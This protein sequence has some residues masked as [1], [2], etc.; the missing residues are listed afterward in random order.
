ME[1]DVINRRQNDILLDIAKGMGKTVEEYAR[2]QNVSE[3]TI[4]N[5][6]KGLN[7]L[8]KTKQQPDIH[9]DSGGRLYMDSAADLSIINNSN[10]YTYKLSP[11]ERKTILSMILLNLDGYITIA[12]LSEMVMMSRNTILSDMDDLKI[13]FEENG[14]ALYSQT[15]KGFT[16]EGTEAN[17]RAGM[18]KLLLLN[19]FLYESENMLASDIFHSL[20]LRVLNKNGELSV[21][22]SLLKAT[23]EK[24]NVFLT[25]FSYREM[26]YYLLVSVNRQRQGKG[27]EE[28]DV[29]PWQEVCKSSKCG[30]AENI[31]QQLCDRYDMPFLQ[32]ELIALIEQLRSKSYIKNNARSIDMIDIQILI[33]EFIYKISC[34]YDIHYYLD[35]Y[36]HDLL[37]NHLKTAVY[38][39]RQNHSLQNTLLHQLETEYPDMFDE[40]EKQLRP[41]EEYIK[42]KISRH[43]ISFIVI[44]ILAVLEKNKARDTLINTLLVCNSGRGTAQL[45]SAKLGTLSKQIKIINIVSSHRIQEMPLKDIDLVVTTVP[46]PQLELPCV[47]INPI[48]SEA[49]L[50]SIQRTVSRMLSEKRSRPDNG[51]KSQI[52]TMAPADQTLL[53]QG[54]AFRELLSADMILLDE[55]AEDWE[56][57][58][59]KA[60]HIL[61]EK[62]KVEKRYIR[63][64]IENIHL[65][66][67]YVV[68]YPGIAIPH[69][70]LS[71]GALEAG[72]SIVRLANPVNFDHEE[73]DP[74]TFVIA[75]S[76]IDSV[77]IGRALYNLSKMLGMENF[78]PRLKSA[79]TGKELLEVI[80]EYEQKIDIVGG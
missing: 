4:K 24:N 21:I 18:L 10:F 74:V 68:I 54:A 30:M 27:L 32:T 22:Q 78:I 58:V 14:L 45:I 63:Q 49:D 9:L 36:L 46:L 51:A 64:M 28:A 77:S 50:Y 59:S 48:M 65:N 39:I 71:G 76:V 52:Q 61:H 3:Q 43:E 29:I 19:D 75:F 73:N 66:G 25:D 26:S 53:E 7:S 23:E 67:P 11:S 6:I 60:G 80:E 5:D 35:F 44:Y 79:R 57:A 20:L 40:V 2:E 8:L 34:S 15:R 55:T 16:V 69:A 47:L 42:S 37:V 62:G 72:A 41:L 33:N 70:D 56:E 31:L 17:I 1:V 12:E 13:W 38:R